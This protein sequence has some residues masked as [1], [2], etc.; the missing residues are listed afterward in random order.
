MS[1]ARTIA[2]EHG[3]TL[4][5][6]AELIAPPKP[7]TWADLDDRADE[8]PAAIDPNTEKTGEAVDEPRTEVEG[9]T[10]PAEPYVAPAPVG[11]LTDHKQPGRRAT[12]W[13]VRQ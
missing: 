2:K 6:V 12:A 10:L 7:R 3:L 4:A 1:D 11:E 9:D 5:D 13:S 8:V